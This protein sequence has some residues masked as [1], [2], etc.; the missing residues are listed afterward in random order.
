MG[1]SIHKKVRSSR[2]IASG[3]AGVL[4][5]TMAGSA[6]A[7]EGP[8][9]VNR[10]PPVYPRGA[11]S[12]GIEGWVNLAFSVDENGNVVSP[13]VVEANPPGVFDSAAIRA[14][15]KWKYTPVKADNLQVKLS[16][17]LQ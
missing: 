12:R 13:R 7:A 15:S 1:K 14:I 10:E 9:P 6:F 4:V 16:F 5:A 3:L 17:K 8:T 11:E 2:R